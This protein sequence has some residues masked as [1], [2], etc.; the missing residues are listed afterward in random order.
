[1]PADWLKIAFV[2]PDGET[3][4]ARA[5][6]VVMARAKRIY[7]LIIKVYQL[8][9]FFLMSQLRL[10]FFF[11]SRPIKA[12]LTL[13]EACRANSN[14]EGYNLEIILCLGISLLSSFVLNL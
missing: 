1:M 7:I 14:V 5:V 6:D 8:F 13:L 2:E 10:N 12:L 11:H 3:Q 4:L 9:F